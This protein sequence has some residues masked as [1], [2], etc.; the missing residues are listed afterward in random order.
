MKHT[1]SFRLPELLA[2]AGS[3]EGL[4]AVIRA[5]ADAV[6]V[7]GQRFGARAY[8]DNPGEDA[9]LEAIDYAHLRGVRVY[10]T[11]NTLLKNSEMGE[12]Y[13]YLL[14]Y[15]E[16]GVDAV[17][18]QDFGVL[19]FLREHF[20]DLPLH[21]STQ[22]TVTDADAAVLAGRWGIRRIVPARE[23]SLPELRA[24]KR[25]SGLEVEIFVHGA[26]CYCYSGQC[27]YSS[28]L[29]G[30]SGNRGRCAQ[31]C[32]LLNIK[33]KTAFDGSTSILDEPAARHHL[34]PKDLNTIDLLPEFVLSGMDSLKIEGRMKKPEYAAGVVSVYRKYLDMTADL[35]ASGDR[36]LS[37]YR[38][39][40]EDRQMLYDLY[41]R[42]GFTDGY[43]HR[44]N[45]PE[46]MAPV[47]HEL[48]RE[49]TEA[50]HRLYEKM[51]G[52]FMTEELCLP[53]S[54]HVT[55]RRGRPM[56]AV[57][58][59][60]DFYAA[61]SGDAPEAARKQPLT[62][63][64]IEEQMKK[65]GGTDFRIDSV[66]VDTDEKSFVP[67]SALNALRRDALA[68]L[69]E[70]ILAGS[71][72]TAPE[73]EAAG[74]AAEEMTG[75]TAAGADREMPRL[76]VLISTKEQLEATLSS[77]MADRIYL[78]SAMICAAADP[79][80]E[81]VRLLKRCA[82]VCGDLHIAL[83]MAERAGA[84]ARAL[85]EAWDTL[86]AAGLKGYLVRAMGSLLRLLDAGLGRAA[87]LDAGMYTFNDE[88]VRFFRDQGIS[89]FTAP[90]ELTKKELFQRDSRGSECVIYG[91]LPLMVSA[92][93]LEKNTAGCSRRNAVNE[94]TDRMGVK[95]K[96]KSECVFCYNVIYN[97]V[98][99]SLLKEMKPLL[100]MGFDGFR[101]SFTLESGEETAVIL[102]AA[103]GALRGG[104]GEIPGASTRGH[105]M[106]GVE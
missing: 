11:V 52:R 49:E 46:M 42:T 106:R 92:Q 23:L 90:F 51:H 34:S 64:R 87:R 65:A 20:P 72:R 2:P 104:S 73:G 82:P 29:G 80:K 61:A 17:L 84:D 55:V 53:A 28:L 102:R 69:A 48:T 98:P 39:S 3:A 96:V 59:S 79:V 85:I 101:L 7:G 10:M 100:S 54:L 21:A 22:M 68:R 81:A 77:H 88:A 14:P 40:R 38:V 41:N 70:T 36:T 83:P 30:R 94:L 89:A 75:G 6:Y 35:Y 25:E 43:F 4:R 76:S 32:R 103:H 44:H 63:N 74:R 18:V 56:E 37:S 71:L 50:R 99:L 19:A 31:P 27:L 67:M 26:L 13:S 12:L 95:F 91:R 97:S 66:T 45:G 16:R 57:A 105:F 8:A 33:G 15:Y 93:C 1:D 78:E 62:A 86:S 58:Q 47:K 24:L 60:G 5:G 9:M